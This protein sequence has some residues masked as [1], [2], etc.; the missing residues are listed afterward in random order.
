MSVSILSGGEKEASG[1]GRRDGTHSNHHLRKEQ[2]RGK[3]IGIPI[4][5]GTR[6]TNEVR[7]K[8][9]NMKGTK[10]KPNLKLSNVP[11]ILARNVRK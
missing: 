2:A 5:R 10:G 6:V 9:S 1:A 7:L 3:T 4:G 8:R 11:M